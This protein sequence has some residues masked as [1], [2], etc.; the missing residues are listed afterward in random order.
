MKVV[1]KFCKDVISLAVIFNLLYFDVNDN[2]FK[3]LV[4]VDNKDVN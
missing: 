1:I 2:K 3:M 4:I